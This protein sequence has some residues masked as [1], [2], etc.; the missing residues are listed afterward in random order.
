MPGK[1][2]HFSTDVNFPSTPSPTYSSSSLP[3]SYG[4]WTPPAFTPYLPTN[5]GIPAMHPVLCPASTPHLVFDVTLPAEN[6]KPNPSYPL[7]PNIL[8][9]DATSPPLPSIVLTLPQLPRWPIIIKPSEGKSVRVM[10]V[11]HGI[12]TS[13]RL[14]AA[15]ADFQ[16]LPP[17]IQSLVTGA[18]VRRYTRMPD[19]TSAKLEKSKGLK[20]VDFLGAGVKFVGLSKSMEGPNVW[21]LHLS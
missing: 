16:A 2:V 11:I 20:R 21:Q 7:S 3:S 18:F 12:Y 10:D 1:H 19:G 4:P 8:L 5:G 15:A 13:L 14:G 9:A 17:H 6:V